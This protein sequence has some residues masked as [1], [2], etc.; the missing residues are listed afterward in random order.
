[1]QRGETINGVSP[2]MVMGPT[3]PGRKLT[4]SGDTR[5]CD[6]LREAARNSDL[7]IH[8]ST[9]AIED[10]ERAHQTG[11]STATQ[12]A[13]VAREAEVKLLALNH[14]SIRYPARLLRDEAREIFPNTVL[15]RDFDSIE[16]PFAERGEPE[17]QRWSDRDTA[18]VLPLSDGAAGALHEDDDV[19]GADAADNV[20]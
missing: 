1:M 2:E 14:L 4:I 19:I 7:L 3:R 11:H 12:A 20:S 18:A 13:W 16:I 9:F 17:L 10:A 5:P 6:A 8:E 15:P